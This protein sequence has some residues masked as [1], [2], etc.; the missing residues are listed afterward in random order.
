MSLAAQT[1]N[2]M[3]WNWFCKL[4]HRAGRGRGEK[5][6]KE[7]GPADPNLTSSIMKESGQARQ[8]TFAAPRQKETKALGNASSDAPLTL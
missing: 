5:R 8:Q 6:E 1:Y 2:F 3:I 4:F 7:A